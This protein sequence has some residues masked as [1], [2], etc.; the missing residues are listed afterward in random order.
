MN[1]P[2]IY[3]AEVVA[4]DIIKQSNK[5]GI[6]ITNVRLSRL[7]YLVQAYALVTLDRPAF[8]EDFEA[9]NYGPIIPGVF[10]KYSFCG[11]YKIDDSV[12]KRFVVNWN[13]ANLMDMARYVEY[14]PID[15]ELRAIVK[16]VIKKTK[17]YTDF[18]LIQMSLKSDPWKNV[19]DSKNIHKIVTKESIK[20]YF[21]KINPQI[22][23]YK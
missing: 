21:T 20:R 2:V 12:V 7:L 22:N 8:E 13:A 4:A 6:P 5:V 11:T 1:N 23:K 18:N 14:E 16:E 9:W 10:A 19:F 3:E 15:D 17:D